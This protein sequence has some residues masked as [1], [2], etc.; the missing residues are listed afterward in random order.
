MIRG[1]ARIREHVLSEM[2]T[3]MMYEN[4]EALNLIIQMLS[5]LRFNFRVNIISFLLKVYLETHSMLC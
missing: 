1:S 2:A 3:R 5:I 4:Y